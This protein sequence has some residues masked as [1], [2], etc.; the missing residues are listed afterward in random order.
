MYTVNEWQKRILKYFIAINGRFNIFKATNKE[1][2]FRNFGSHKDANTDVA[3]SNLL[4]NSL[5]IH[6]HIN[7]KDIYQLNTFDDDKKTEIFRIISG[8]KQRTEIMQPD[9]SETKGLIFQFT[10]RTD[11]RVQNQSTYYHYT[12]NDDVDFWITLIKKQITTKPTKIIMG[13]IRDPK[14]RIRRIIEA[15]KIISSRNE[16]G[17]FFRKQIEDIDQEACGNN[18]QPSKAAFEIFLH[19]GWIE[20][21]DKKGRTKMYRLIGLPNYLCFK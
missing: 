18:R 10:P 6:S 2:I 12:K 13:S 3:W 1:E 7:D 16:D 19:K 21:V 20:E 5:I 17:I 11:P 4:A 14:S 9:E 15:V 8:D